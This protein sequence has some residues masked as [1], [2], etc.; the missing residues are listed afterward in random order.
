[1][2][3]PRSHHV[4]LL[5]LCVALLACAGRAPPASAQLCS[6]DFGT[7]PVTTK[8]TLRDTALKLIM[9]DTSEKLPA[10]TVASFTLHNSGAA[11]PISLQIW[12]PAATKTLMLVCDTKATLKA[13]L[14]TIDAEPGCEIEDGD[15]IGWYQEGGGVVGGISAD[16]IIQEADATM[17]SSVYHKFKDNFPVGVVWKYC[18][19]PG[20]DAPGCP[21]VPVG[22]RFDVEGC[23]SRK[24]VLYSVQYTAAP[25]R[26]ESTEIDFRYTYMFQRC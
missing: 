13:G 17:C 22:G 9:V 25:V 6:S 4:V 1:M 12:R 18:G 14:Q 15:V 5:Q 3:P 11:A 23:G 26:S 2:P 16:Q 21:L 19:L 10:G 8:Q 20:H 7:V 24:Y